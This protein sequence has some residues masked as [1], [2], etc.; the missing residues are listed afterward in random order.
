MWDG[1]GPM[2]MSSRLRGR[3]IGSMAGIRF[4]RSV[5]DAQGPGWTAVGA[6]R[7]GAEPLIE[8]TDKSRALRVRWCP[9]DRS[10]PGGHRRTLGLPPLDVRV[11]QVAHL[12]GRADYVIMEGMNLDPRDR[13]SNTDSSNHHDPIADAYTNNF[14]VVTI[15]VRP[16]T[17][18]RRA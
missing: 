4:V 12:T 14:H 16:T 6:C 18:P 15:Y 11:H 17:R 7:P 3:L 5:A 8:V 1:F 9:R 2:A 13:T 10:D